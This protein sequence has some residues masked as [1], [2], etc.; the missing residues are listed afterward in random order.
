MDAS[1]FKIV[2]NALTSYIYQSMRD[3]K[4]FRFYD[5]N[6][7]EIALKN[8]LFEVVIYCDEDV[9]GIAR[10]VGDGKIVFF[11]KDVIVNPKYQNMG[12][13][14]LLMKTIFKYISDNACKGAYVG[15][16]STPGKEGFYSK[17]GFIKRP[18]DNLG[19]GMVL[20]YDN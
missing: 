6:D 13:G 1:N 15:L 3:P 20:F 12:C 10:V 7:V 14:D 9:A 19:S 18:T 4:L 17:Y 5:F 16:M 8:D 2:K 11:L